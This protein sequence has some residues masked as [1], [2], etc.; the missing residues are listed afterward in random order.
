[1][2]IM[3]LATDAGLGKDNQKMNFAW[4]KMGSELRTM[5]P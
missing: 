4:Y 1:M 5:L 3:L 2:D